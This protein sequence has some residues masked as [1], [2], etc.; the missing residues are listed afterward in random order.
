MNR[1]MAIT[2]G[3]TATA[4]VIVQ[5]CAGPT[6]GSVAQAPEPRLG[7]RVP[8]VLGYSLRVVRPG[9][10]VT[11]D[12]NPSR[13]TVEVDEANRIRRAAVG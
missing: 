9:E 5:A 10:A 8:K 1:R 7:D 13:L 3:G 12:Y 4:A 2:A 11:M 6:G